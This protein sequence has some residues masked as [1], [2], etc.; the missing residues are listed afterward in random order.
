MRR[1]ELTDELTPDDEVDP[2]R[3]FDRRKWH[4]KPPGPGRKAMQLC[5][6]VKDVLVGAVV[7]G[8][9]VSVEPCPHAG[10]LLV[11]VAV[12]TTADATDRAT[13]LD[14]LTRQAG[15]LRRLVAATISRRKVPELVFAV[16]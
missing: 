1:D 5:S 11:T 4:L 7:E 16:G 10:R 15:E 9:V 12:N 13:V 8:V 2:V 6:Q 3:Y 14:Q